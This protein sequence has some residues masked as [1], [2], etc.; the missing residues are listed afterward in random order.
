MIAAAIKLH[1]D[2]TAAVDTG[3]RALLFAST[4]N[5]PDGNPA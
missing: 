4:R 3:I 5:S 2:A 1:I